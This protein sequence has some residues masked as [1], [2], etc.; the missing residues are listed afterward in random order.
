MF[1]RVFGH[2]NPSRDA[3]DHRI[4][5]PVM[6]NEDSILRPVNGA[7]LH[8]S[9]HPPQHQRPLGSTRPVAVLSG[10]TAGGFVLINRSPDT[11]TRLRPV[12]ARQGSARPER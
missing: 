9:S 6:I 4:E 5:H 8:H 3:A 2:R 12:W 7:S 10:T 11:Y 1:L